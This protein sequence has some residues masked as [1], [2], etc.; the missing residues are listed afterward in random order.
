M[1]ITN[2]TIRRFLNLPTV[3]QEFFIEQ[4]DAVGVN[5]NTL[6]FINKPGQNFT[7]LDD[8][9][10]SVFLVDES[11]P[12]FHSD[13]NEFLRVSNPKYKFCLLVD[14]FCLPSKLQLNHR[15]INGLQYIADPRVL[16][17]SYNIGENVHFDHNVIIGGE[18]FSPVIGDSRYE[19]V[20]FPQKGGVIIGDNVTIKYNT[21]I[22]R[23]TFG[24]TTIGDNT[25]IDY[26]CQ[27]GHNCVIGKSCIIAA[28][29]I[30]GGS[31]V[32]GDCVTVGIG[33]KIR[34]GIKI[35]DGASIG[36]G[37]VV[38]KDVPANTVVVGNPAHPIEH[39]HIFSEKGLV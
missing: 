20:Q 2:N 17:D 28:G 16:C 36:M 24:Y 37:A 21:M 39:D 38:T 35:G 14:R 11:Y 32:L 15:H 13:D 31:T 34:N 26:G 8:S 33:A 27:I 10:H 6:M 7:A 19:L 1:E 12:E 5:F 29:T 9:H 22:G 18:D 23:G 25:M 3:E 4:I 30:I